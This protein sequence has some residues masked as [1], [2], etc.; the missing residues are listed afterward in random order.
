MISI[1]SQ[2]PKNLSVLF[3]FS[4]G[5]NS[6]LTH[7]TPTRFTVID[8]TAITATYIAV[9][10]DYTQDQE[11]EELYFTGVMHTL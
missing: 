3:R 7:L 10:F 4:K 8:N 2:C 6:K 11:M 5:K 9:W 1:D